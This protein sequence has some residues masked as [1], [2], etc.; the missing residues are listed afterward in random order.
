[1]QLSHRELCLT[2]LLTALITISGSLKIPSFVPGSEFQLS[3]PIAVA[4]CGVFGIKRYLTAGIAASVLCLVLGTQN[5]FNVFIALSFR[6]VVACC[7][8]LWGNS[9]LFY[10][11]AGPLASTTARLLLSLFVGKAALALIAAAVPG[12]IFTAFT[13]PLFAAVL[14]RAAFIKAYAKLSR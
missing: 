4:I 12:M 1:M 6:T 3:A 14:N 11:L 5:V 8:L 7:S 9:K 10:V 13:A 2:A